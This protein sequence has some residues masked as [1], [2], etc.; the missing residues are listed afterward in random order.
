[1]RKYAAGAMSAGL[2]TAALTLVVPA[3]ASAS[4]ATLT[5][6]TTKGGPSTTCPNWAGWVGRPPA[7]DSMTDVQVS[8]VIPPVNCANKIG[9]SPD[10]HVALWVGFDGIA[11][12]STTEPA[13]TDGINTVEQTGVEAI[14]NGHSATSKATWYPF[15]EMVQQA[16]SSLLHSADSAPKAFTANDAHPVTGDT[17]NVSVHYTKSSGLYHFGYSAIAASGSTVDYS[18]TAKCRKWT[19]AHPFVNHCDNA[20]AEVI[21]EATGGGPNDGVSVADMGTASYQDAAV[22]YTRAPSPGIYGLPFG[23]L[24]MT[25]VIMSPTGHPGLVTPSA[26]KPADNAGPNWFTTKWKR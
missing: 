19:I 9:A 12:N 17:I 22:D 26:L 21:T 16:T 10:G 13:G 20:S 4:S 5:D 8:F 23:T 18:A 3:A 2:L 15:Y 1:M 24:R 14:C 6:C 7:H 25:K 11:G